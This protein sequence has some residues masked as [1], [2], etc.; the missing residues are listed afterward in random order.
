[1]GARRNT[2]RPALGGGPALTMHLYQDTGGVALEERSSVAQVTIRI[3][4]VF[5]PPKPRKTGGA[6]VAS[7]EPA[8]NETQAEPKPADPAAAAEPPQPSKPSKSAPPK[9]GSIA[10]R[11]AA[12]GRGIPFPGSPRP[13][14][15]RKPAAAHGASF[16]P[17]DG[18]RGP[19]NASS[20]SAPSRDDG[21][22]VI[23]EID[24]GPKP[25]E[26]P[27]RARRA[28]NVRRSTA[29]ADL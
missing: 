26:L 25:A 5:M 17:P 24:V 4:A 29:L 23:T 16:A 27:V 12:L 13:P 7:S 28:V 9:P 2:H 3:G 10:A 6:D 18:E 8:P 14:R 19:A 21:G 15:P 22:S 11:M 20:E 1:V